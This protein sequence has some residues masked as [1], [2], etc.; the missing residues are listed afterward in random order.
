MTTLR[1]FIAIELDPQVR[2][3][4]AAVQET[5]RSLVPARSVRW[6]QTDCIHL[7]LKFLGDTPLAQVDSIKEAL[8]RAAREVEPF[9]FQVGSTG[10]FPN[11]RRPRVLWISLHEPSGTLARLR[12]AVEAYVAPLGFPTEAR[13]FTPHLTLGRVQ[14][15]ALAADVR[16]IGEVMTPGSSAVTATDRHATP[17]ARVEVVSYIKSDLRPTGAVYTTLSVARLSGPAA[18]PGGRE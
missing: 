14:Q 15:Y 2:A 5:L 12:D 8:A 10:C 17:Q 1:T 13:A 6:V 3:Y 16:R 4:L 9:T 11:Q 7:T 18:V